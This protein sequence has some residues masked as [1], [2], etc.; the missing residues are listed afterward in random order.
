MRFKHSGKQGDVIYAL[1]ALKACRKSTLFL[2][3]GI[4]LGFGPGEASQLLP[5]LLRQPYI[6]TAKIW[7]GEA[8]DYDLAEFRS[9]CPL[10]MN[11]ADAQLNV[12][13]LSSLWRDEP[14]LTVSHPPSLGQLVVFARSLAHRG[15]PGFWEV[16][17]RV[18]G[19]GALF[20]GSAEEHEEFIRVTGP[21]EFAQTRNLLEAAELIAGASLFVGNQSCP[22]AIAEGL[23]VPVIQETYGVANCVFERADA[24]QVR[25]PEDLE[26]I[27]PFV[28]R[29]LANSPQSHDVRSGPMHEEAQ[30]QLI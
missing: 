6:E 11:L 1:P 29:V 2:N 17:Y 7:E 13:G 15:V 30:G 9:L 16:C 20:M 10:S 26:L 5:L 4:G 23:K 3:T 14:W 25:T 19:A 21:V 8:F 24:L 28:T 18:A 12:I 27:D 22:F